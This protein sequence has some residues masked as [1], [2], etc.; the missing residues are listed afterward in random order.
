MKKSNFALSLLVCSIFM[1]QAFADNQDIQAEAEKD[2][3][4]A[5][6]ATYLGDKS[7]QTDSKINEI[8]VSQDIEYQTYNDE[9]ASYD[10]SYKFGN[11]KNYAGSYWFNLV[12]AASLHVIDAGEGQVIPL[13]GFAVQA[14]GNYMVTNHQL[15]TLSLGTSR[16]AAGIFTHYS[17]A[18]LYGLI[19]KGERGYISGS[20]GA[21]LGN[22]S[23][24]E[25]PVSKSIGVTGQTQAFL[26]PTK[27]FGFGLVTS[28]GYF[29][30][31]SSLTFTPGLGIQ[32]G[33]LKS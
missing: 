9:N 1:D 2:Q 15:L 8:F 19:L 24:A 20:A 22:L 17:T 27:N 18:L 31:A 3:N 25:I 14:S 5:F 30:G 10:G 26:T 16:L 33:K 29:P 23:F 28:V 7:E 6:Q 4:M 13:A 21:E 32:L 11:T 12:T